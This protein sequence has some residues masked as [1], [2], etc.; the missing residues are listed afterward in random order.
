LAHST[1]HFTL[2]K[3]HF[4]VPRFIFFG[5]KGGVGKTTCAAAWALAEAGAGRRVLVVST[6]PAHSLGDALG[7]R[8]SSRV[9]Q[10]RLGDRTLC[11]MEL[12]GP[13]AYARW[14]T[15]NRRALGDAIEHG[16][17]LD[18]EDVDAL[19][20][21]SIPGVDELVGL[22]EIV[23]VADRSPGYHSV[24]IDTAPTGHTLR[25]LAAPGTVAAVADVLNAL[26]LEH[27]LI[28]EQLAGVGRPEAADRLAS[29]LAEQARTTASRLRDSRRALFHWV[30]LPEALS[31]A[32]SVKG[33]RALVR[34]GIRVPHVIVNRVLPDGPPCLICDRRRETE[35]QIVAEIPTRLPRRPNQRIVQAERREPRGAAALTRIGKQLLSASR[36]SFDRSTRS[37]PLRSSSGD[38]RRETTSG[39][40]LILSVSKDAPRISADTLPELQGARLLMFGG[41]GGVGKTTVAAATAVRLAG[42]DPQRRVLLISTDPAHSL[43]HAFDISI[44][45]RPRRIPLGPRNL[46]VRELDAAAALAKRRSDLES[47]LH[48][49]VEAFGSRQLVAEG[50]YGV[51]ELVDLAPPGIDELLGILDVAECVAAGPTPASP[52]RSPDETYDLVIVDTA[53]TGHAL[54]LLEMPETAREWVQVLLRVLLKYRQLVRPG[55]LAKELLDLSKSIRGLQELLHDPVS[56]RFVIVTRA[57]AV[58]RLET[59]RLIARLRRLKLASPA[60]VANAMTLAPGRCSWCRATSGD[61]RRELAALARTARHRS[62]ECAIILTPLSAPPPRGV[63]ALDWWSKTWTRQKAPT[64]TA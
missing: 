24:V 23:R 3:S 42:A 50:G 28:R 64:S 37:R 41:K 38:V 48:E 55:Q 4:T 52:P 56:T 8:L 45:D 49:I 5:G 43:G 33:L 12:D 29:L 6:D 16:T 25:L 14:L 11:A 58:P 60:I 53:P 21:L 10:I 44:G 15:L 63:A 7:V 34:L 22:L 35:R 17:W 47:A 2:R 1:S 57:A 40:G 39:Q 13:R 27:R 20:Q 36:S 61:E 51:Q 59:E 30:L 18:R 26:Q 19:L 9:S 62:R 32:E 46:Q 31:V 54:R